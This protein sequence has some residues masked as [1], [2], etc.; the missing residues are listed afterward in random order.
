MLT[1]AV[2]NQKGGVGKTTSAIGLGR[3]LGLAGHRVLV[4]DLDPQANAS[5]ILADPPLVE[6]QAGVANALSAH[7]GL[8]LHDVITTTMWE[9]VLLAPSGGEA[10]AGVRDEL[11][12]AGPGREAR[13]AEQLQQVESDFDVVLID[14]APALDLLTSNALAAAD[15]VLIV[16]QSKLLSLTGLAHLL[17]TIEV[18]RRN[19]NPSLTIAGVLVNLH[20][21]GTLAGVHWL[22]DLREAC[23][24]QGLPLLSSTRP[25]PDASS[26]PTPTPEPSSPTSKEAPNETPQALPHQI[27]LDYRPCGRSTARP[28][29]G[30]ASGRAR[31]GQCRTGQYCQQNRQCWRTRQGG[32]GGARRQGDRPRRRGP[33]GTLPGGLH[34]WSPPRRARIVRGVDRGSAGGEAR[35]GGGA[36]GAGVRAGGHRPR[37]QGPLVERPPRWRPESPAL[38]ALLQMVVYFLA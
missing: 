2:T 28:R 22:N 4:V 16:T 19:L 37:P 17:D 21:A 23:A 15:G 13:L 7:S 31:H 26:S 32:P 33:G 3:A 10:L 30:A 6:D 38:P 12:I 29:G 11:I 14:C 36:P 8:A 9:R 20:E 18:A 34:R 1:I 35:P 25:S 24:R 27:R 5:A